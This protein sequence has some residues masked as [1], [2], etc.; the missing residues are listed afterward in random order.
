MLVAVSKY[1]KPLAEVDV[2]RAEHHQYLKPFFESGKL[3]I[4]GRQNNNSGGVII[5]RSLSKEAFEQILAQDPFTTAGAAEYK[6]YE[7]NP[8]FYHECLADMVEG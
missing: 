4:S 1:L 5:T 8:S 6:L 7:F 3:L 2:H